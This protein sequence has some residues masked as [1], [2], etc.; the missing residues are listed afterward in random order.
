MNQ[1]LKKF[2]KSAAQQAAGEAKGVAGG[3]ALWES[4]GGLAPP[5]LLVISFRGQPKETRETTVSV[6]AVQADMTFLKV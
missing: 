6:Q 1:K 2:C 3:K 5:Q 4:I